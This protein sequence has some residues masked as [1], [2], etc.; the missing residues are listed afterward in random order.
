MED[1]DYDE[2]EYFEIDPEWWRKD[3]SYLPIHTFQKHVDNFISELSENGTLPHLN[4]FWDKITTTMMNEYRRE[5][6]YYYGRKPIDTENPEIYGYI[7]GFTTIFL[8][9]VC[10][11]FENPSDP[12]KN[13]ILEFYEKIFHRK[14]FWNDT[15][16]DRIDNIIQQIKY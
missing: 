9:I 13:H 8:K 14:R 15:I 7:S 4:T 1:N 11:Y 12:L 10:Y 3:L 16:L 6:N 5:Y 2:D